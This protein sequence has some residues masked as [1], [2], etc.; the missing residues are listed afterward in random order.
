MPRSMTRKS[1]LSSPENI[2]YETSRAG[3]DF[4]HDTGG[5]SVFLLLGSITSSAETECTY[6]VFIPAQSP[7]PIVF[8][9]T[10]RLSYWWLSY[11]W[12]VG[13]RAFVFQ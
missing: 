6:T 8:A 12:K 10:F 13:E 7:R 3:S 2:N 9:I 1:T 5:P 4:E 11:W